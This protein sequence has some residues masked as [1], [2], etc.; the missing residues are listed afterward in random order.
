VFWKLNLGEKKLNHSDN[1][2]VF[3]GLGSCKLR[4]KCHWSSGNGERWDTFI[5]VKMTAP[6]SSVCWRKWGNARSWGLSWTTY[7]ACLIHPNFLG[8]YD[9]HTC[10]EQNQKCRNWCDAEGTSLPCFGPTMMCVQAHTPAQQAQGACGSS[11]GADLSIL[12]SEHVFRAEDPEWTAFHHLV[13]ARSSALQ[14]CP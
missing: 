2:T 12:H 3:H 14:L 4:L 13:A 11:V 5:K 8:L 10:W 6:W 1:Q 9:S 7:P